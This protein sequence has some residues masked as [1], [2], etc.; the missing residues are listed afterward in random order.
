MEKQEFA[1]R[2]FI[3]LVTRTE[4]GRESPSDLAIRAIRF[5]D[6]FRA[7]W[8]KHGANADASDDRGRR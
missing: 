7:E 6:D 1:Q 5:A 4:M 8:D 2:I 3:E